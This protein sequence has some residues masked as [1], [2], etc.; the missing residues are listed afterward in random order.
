V[1]AAGYF[2][3]LVQ[4]ARSTMERVFALYRLS[5]DPAG[6]QGLLTAIR[7]ASTIAFAE[8]G[9]RSSRIWRD[10]DGGGGFLLI[11]EWETPQRLEAHM[12]RPAFRRFLEVLE[13]SHSPP[14]ILYIE[15]W[16]LRGLDWMTQVLGTPGD[17]R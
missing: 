3:I 2:S 8:P 16:R 9:C 1:S 5:Q 11:E 7:S 4:G 10:A 12:R 13:L 17:E 14:E 6:S 15:G